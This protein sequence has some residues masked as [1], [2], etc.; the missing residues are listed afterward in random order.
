MI[1]QL[2]SAD[3][4]SPPNDNS[5]ENDHVISS[6]LPWKIKE[7]LMSLNNT[8]ETSCQNNFSFKG[9]FNKKFSLKDIAIAQI[10]TMD[11]LRSNSKM[12][13]ENDSNAFPTLSS[14]CL[15]IL[16][17]VS[18]DIGKYTL[19]YDILVHLIERL[20]K[21]EKVTDENLN[22]FYPLDN[23]NVEGNPITDRGLTYYAERSRH[24]VCLTVFFIN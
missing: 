13:N 18:N 12:I 2:G 23:L 17:S 5:P 11:Q 21:E 6:D 16:V 10:L 4:P 8:H 22:A 7:S 15:D 14:L 24:H 19:P 20:R 1:T 9:T 3:D